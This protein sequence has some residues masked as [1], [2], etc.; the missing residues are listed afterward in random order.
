MRFWDW[1]DPWIDRDRYAFTTVAIFIGLLTLFTTAKRNKITSD[2]HLMNING[3]LL[4][5]S[6]KNGS[7]GSRMYD[8][9]LSGYVC[10]FRIPADYLTCF[11]KVE[12][13]KNKLQGKL[14]KLK[15]PKQERN[16]LYREGERVIVQEIYTD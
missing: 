11:D 12:F 7:R 3:S 16:K 4:N 6:F 1:I 2:V 14:I 13:V 8:F 5:Y 10:T 15:I 9:W